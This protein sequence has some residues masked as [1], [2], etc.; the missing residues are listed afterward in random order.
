MSATKNYL[1]TG[2]N[3]GLGLDASRQLSLLP[4]TKMVY[5]ACRT[6]SKA[7]KAIDDIV[8]NAN[9]PNEKLKFVKFDCSSSKDIIEKI[10]DDL[11]DGEKLDGLI[12]NAG[13]M[14]RGEEVA[15]NGHIVSM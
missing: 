9:A 6:E 3:S 15:W 2:A 4:D 10:V 7:L 13:G 8:S 5:L 11:P 14:V 1:V 12:L